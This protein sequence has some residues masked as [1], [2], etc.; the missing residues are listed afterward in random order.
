MRKFLVVV[1]LTSTIVSTNASAQDA[2]IIPP[3]V[4]PAPV[5]HM[6]PTTRTFAPD[7]TANAIERQRLS[8][9]DAKQQRLDEMLDSKLDI[10]RC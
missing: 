4:P 10:C 5:G 6:Q 2:G 1:I 7:S 8:T 3:T 9:F